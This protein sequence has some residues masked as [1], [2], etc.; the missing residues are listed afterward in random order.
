M[1]HSRR[2][3]LRV[4]V[5]GLGG[6]TVASLL[7]ACGGAGPTAVPGKPTE[8]KPAEAAKPAAPA[9]ATAAP[10]EAA[11]P[12]AEAKPAQAAPGGFSGG[13]SLKLL[14]RS[15][16]VPAFDTWFDKWAADWGA[17]NKVAIEVDHILAAEL[18]AKWAAEVATGDG[19]DLFTFTQSGA[20]NVFN[21][22]LVDLSDLAKQVGDAHGGWVQPLSDNIAKYEGVWR[23]VPDFFIDF[24]ANYRKDL[25]D[26]AGLKPFDTW[27]DVMNGGAI[28]KEKG[29][30]VGI[31]INQKSNDANNS[32]AGL[33]WS[34]GA[35]YVKEDG[36][37]PAINSPETKEAVKFALELYKKTMTNEVL[38]WDDTGNNQMLASGRAS[39]I[40]NPISS[41]R[42][43][44]KDNKELA[45]KISMSDAPA[46][47]K[48]RFAS[49]SVSV[50]GVMN[51]SK[52]QEAAKALLTEYY[53]AYPE[54]VKVSEG[55]NQ[56]VLMK[57]RQKPMAVLGEDPRLTLLQDFDKSAR[58]VGHPGPPTSAAAE[59]E[60]NWIIPLMIGQAVQTE[61]VD[62]AVDWATQKIEAIYAKYK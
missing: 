29:N 27:D 49:V 26:A 56:P 57:Y 50:W 62:A 24:P 41:L 10:A 31:A 8:S 45:Q 12:A 15:H 28:L 35:S 17:K 53:Q 19:H 5:L 52:N 9:A 61:N 54:T 46:G 7:A 18:P 22:S 20:I 40:Q 44:E 51:W 3:F 13:G 30:P 33:L 38:S 4:S 36:K 39:W 34:Y 11:K 42:T 59:V 32:W 14:M 16:F 25:F 6:V 60:Q 37:T 43:I 23:G 47:P 58:V 48:G 55:Y 1:A 21:K 2:Q